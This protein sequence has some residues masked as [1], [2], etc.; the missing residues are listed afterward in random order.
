MLKSSK[1]MSES[2]M[3][4]FEDVCVPQAC[5][6]RIILFKW[7]TVVIKLLAKKLSNCVAGVLVGPWALRMTD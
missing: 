6:I 4:W 7:E 3:G 2:D 5:K 1:A